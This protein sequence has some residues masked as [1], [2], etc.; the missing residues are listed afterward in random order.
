MP[1]HYYSPDLDKAAQRGEPSAVWRAGQDRRLEMIRQYGG[2]S[3]RGCV[4]VNGTGIGAYQSRLADN[5]R[6][7][8]GLDIEFPRLLEAK[9]HNAHLVCA[10]GEQLPFASGSFDAVLSNEVLEHVEDDRKAVEEISRA[11]VS[12]G[13]LI[14]F[15]P[16]RG[17]PFET[18]GI[19]R[20]GAYQ[21]GNKPFVNYL[22]R[23]WRDKLAPHV[24]VYSRRDM[25]KLVM[26]LPFTKEVVRTIFGAYDNIIQRRP[27]A[28]KALRAL[29]HWMEKTPLQRLGLSHLWV[30]RKE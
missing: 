8:V 10:K 16:N 12:G 18:H 13:R 14:I 6:L 7:M 20:K 23:S 25:S 15:C 9:K 17:Y 30:L 28:G 3:I 26:G 5:A 2:E 27:A 29:L 21:F 19:Y 4:L 22:P 24:R 1:D 11:L